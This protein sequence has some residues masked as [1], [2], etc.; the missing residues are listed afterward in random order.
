MLLAVAGQAVAAIELLRKGGF[1]TLLR[2]IGDVSYLGKKGDVPPPADP[3]SRKLPL[4]FPPDELPH[5]PSGLSIDKFLRGAILGGVQSN[6]WI[7]SGNPTGPDVETLL[8]Q[9]DRYANFALVQGNVVINASRSIPP[10]SGCQL[11]FNIGP[12]TSDRIPE[13]GSDGLEAKPKPFPFGALPETAEGHWIDVVVAS[14]Q[15]EVEKGKGRVF[16]PLNGPSWVCECDPRN[17]HSCTLESRKDYLSFSTIMPTAGD[18]GFRVGVYFKNNLLQSYLVSVVVASTQEATRPQSV[19]V[20]YTIHG[21]FSNLDRLGQKT[22]SILASE[23]KSGEIGFVVNGDFENSVTLQMTEGKL[24]NAITAARSRLRQIHLSETKNLFGGIRTVSLLDQNNGKTR[25][26][27]V[28]DLRNLAPIGALLQTALFQ[29]QPDLWQLLR[30]DVLRNPSTIQIARASTSFVFPWNLIYDIE[31]DLAEKENYT[32][33]KFVEEWKDG[34]GL[35]I[36]GRHSCP[37]E[38]DH[39]RNMLCPFGFWGMRHII[40][41][42]PSVGRRRTLA[43]E[44]KVSKPPASLVTCISND[45]EAKY[46]K[47]HL[48]SIAALA[49]FRVEKFSSKAKLLSRLT[50]VDAGVVYIYCHGGETEVSGTQVTVPY[51]AIGTSEKLTPT[52][53]G[54]LSKDPAYLY[55]TVA[56]PL[57]FINGCHTVDVTPDVLVNFVDAFAGLN[58]SGVVGTE[59]TVHQALANEVGTV[60]LQAFLTK[61]AGEAIRDVRHRL[62][63]KG[64]LMGLAYTAYCLSSLRLSLPPK[65]AWNQQ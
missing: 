35:S 4:P 3:A 32:V 49:N 15:C 5:D 65:T 27:F 12:L 42:P 7:G 38:A 19:L 60:F 26:D 40:E 47:P 2:K 54:T 33:C 10:E 45:L 52:D 51:L 57:V 53:I 63:Q 17:G 34:Q 28:E 29:A 31:L 43:S 55:W 64:N 50:A 58:S 8:P 30:D 24:S 59:V 37:Y 23:L 48:D 39:K 14:G 36:D 13:I 56:S 16:L 20:D 61:S 46:T 22:I 21:S 41:Q 44:I 62:V 9:D 25:A 6:V 1:L 18:V 11:R